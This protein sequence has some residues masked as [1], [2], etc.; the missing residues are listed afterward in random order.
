MKRDLRARPSRL[1]RTRVRTRGTDPVGTG[2]RGLS[3]ISTP[4]RWPT[5]SAHGWRRVY[6]HDT[7][8]TLALDSATV[9]IDIA[10]A[11]FFW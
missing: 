2:P 9:A 8:G 5:A 1:V 4:L 3:Q 6:T 11:A 7:D 10:D